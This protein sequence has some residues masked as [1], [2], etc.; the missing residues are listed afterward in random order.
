MTSSIHSLS[1]LMAMVGSF[2]LVFILIGC[3]GEETPR[4]DSPAITGQEL[5]EHVRF[6]ASD[7][8]KGRETGTPGA[9]RASEYLVEQ[10]KENKVQPG[11]AG[12]YYQRFGF[13][14]G[15]ELG[16]ENAFTLYSRNKEQRLELNEDFRPL[17]FSTS[18]KV[19]GGLVF[20]GYGITAES[21]NYDD[22]ARLNV[23][24][25]IVL[26]L[27]YGPEGDNP[28]GEFGEYLS[29]RYKAMN[30]RDHGAAGII[31]IPGPDPYPEDE[32]VKLR[33]DQAADAGIQ[34]VSAKREPFQPLFVAAGDS[35]KEIQADLNLH[36]TGGGFEFRNVSVRL[37]TDLKYVRKMGRNVIGFLEGTDPTLRHRS[38]VIGAHYDHLGMGG[39]GS[40]VPDTSAVHNGAD[41][42]ASGTAGLLELAEYFAEAENRPEHSLV[43]AAFSGEEIGLLGSSKFVE[44]PPYALDST[45]AMMNMDMIGRPKDSTLILGGTG[46][47]PVWD[48]LLT[49]VNAYFGWNLTKSNVVG[50]GASDHTSFYGKNIPALFFFTGVHE[51]YHRPSDDWQRLNYPGYEE[52]VR[53]VAGVVDSLDTF[54]KPLE[55]VE[56]G[57]ERDRSTDFRVSLQI[58][59]DYAANVHG[60]RISSVRDDG[61]AAEAGMQAGDV[62]VQFGSKKIN[63]IYDYT[64]ALQ[65]FEAGTVVDIIALRNGGQRRFTVQLERQQ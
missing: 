26:V 42:N 12:D 36:K 32:L 25:K 58:I 57:M 47:S 19:S 49:G 6:L 29:L 10:F 63:N 59:P 2:A 56:T 15:V 43:F 55:F 48:S 64:F 44:E 30:A 37:H 14:A 52:V 27:R 11:N 3:T 8:L 46:T 54:R 4:V 23:D 16:Q 60:L 53:F 35:L 24:G 9:N 38:I 39:H 18:G 31:I 20:A 50:V 1:N 62:I 61:P 65:E 5:R 7:E 45:L 41:D 51:D 28:H 40:L 21:L 22:Y 17:G 33:Y 34:A 13:I